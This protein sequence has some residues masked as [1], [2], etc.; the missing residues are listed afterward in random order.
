MPTY[1]VHAPPPRK[2]G[3]SSAPER[4]LFVRDGFHVWAFVLGPLWLLAHRLW[5]VFVIYVVAYGAIGFGLVRIGA[6]SSVQLIIGVL[7]ALLMGF[8]ASSLWR[9][10]LARRGWKTLGFV[11][12]EDAEMAERRFYVEWAERMV[13]NPA[14]PPA[15]TP[16]PQY[17]MPVR[18]GPPTSN[19][20]IGLFPEPGGS[21]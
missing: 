4:F 1:T 5:L 17:A 18:R 8:E 12:G 19:D 9:W 15:A 13:E 20:V 6:S 3:A 10:T 11:I 7:I 2:S 16:E 14:P 21:R